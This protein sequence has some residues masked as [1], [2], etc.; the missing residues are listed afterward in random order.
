MSVEVT[1]V[2]PSH[3]FAGAQFCMVE[4]RW[5]PKVCVAANKFRE[6][7]AQKLCCARRCARRVFARRKCCYSLL[8]S[9]EFLGLLSKDLAPPFVA[10]ADPA[11]PD[12]EHGELDASGRP[13]GRP[14]GADLVPEYRS[15][16]GSHIQRSSR[17][18][19]L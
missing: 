12:E 19:S 9:G 13:H 16:R 8:F 10:R 1:T 4:G 18:E 15:R 11:A 17:T 6:S 5:S 14:G 3:L 2:T 7:M